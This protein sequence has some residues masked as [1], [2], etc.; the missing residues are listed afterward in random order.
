MSPNVRIIKEQG[1]G[2]Y[3]QE[4]NRGLIE[5][6]FQNLPGRTEEKRENLSKDSRCPGRVESNTSWIQKGNIYSSK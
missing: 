4:S 3:F 1:I 5:V 6:I 2:K